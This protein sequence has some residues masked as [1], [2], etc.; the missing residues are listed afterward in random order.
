MSKTTDESVQ[1]TFPEQRVPADYEG[2]LGNGEDIP[3]VIESDGE[4]ER[5]PYCGNWYKRVS[6]HWRL[7]KCQY[8]PISE[9]KIELLKGLMLGDGSMNTTDSYFRCKMTN[10]TFLQWLSNEL[11]WLASDVRK[12]K[13]AVEIADGCRNSLDRNTQA[14]DCVDSYGIHTRP[15]PQLRGFTEWYSTGEIVFP[16]DLQLTPTSLAMW[17][18]SDGGLSW[19]HERTHIMVRFASV[20]ES[21]R[22][23]SIINM[24]EGCDFTVQH[25]KGSNEFYIPQREV[26]DFFEYIGDPVPGFAYKW[27]YEEC[28]RYDRLKTQMR[29][30]HCT[31][32]LE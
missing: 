2:Q 11:G 12:K 9:Y 8:P 10:R 6:S 4:K 32:T 13:T 1:S 30:Q 5:C 19:Q 3:T 16:T 27:A 17:Y 29:E 31:Q 15:H 21:E 20:N 7:G 24:L 14:K 25:G 18:V 26:D 28:D 23:Q 22:P